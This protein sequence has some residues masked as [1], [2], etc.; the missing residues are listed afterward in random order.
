MHLYESRSSLVFF[1]TFLFLSYRIVSA[2]S[3]LSSISLCWKE[4]GAPNTGS[5]YLGSTVK[6]KLKLKICKGWLL[7]EQYKTYIT[8]IREYE[9]FGPLWIYHKNIYITYDNTKWLSI[10][11]LWYRKNWFT[12]TY[13]WTKNKFS[14]LLQLCIFYNYVIKK[15][16]FKIIY[17]TRGP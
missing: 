5:V 11:Y 4:A 9:Q 7:N 17:L 15:N 12:F 2:S 13:M 1:F 8:Q 16:S 10:W 6:I 3:A 14:N